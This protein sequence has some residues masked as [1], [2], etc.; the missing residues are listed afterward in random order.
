MPQVS[1]LKVV[2]PGME[3]D[4]LSLRPAF[5]ALGARTHCPVC[6]HVV[7]DPALDFIN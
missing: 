7:P 4:S 2:E 1:Q 3:L 5:L 6:V